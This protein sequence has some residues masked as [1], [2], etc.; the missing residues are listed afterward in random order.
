VQKALI[1]AASP[2]E[3]ALL[4]EKP[5]ERGVSLAAQSISAVGCCH[6]PQRI[7]CMLEANWGIPL[8]ELFVK[9]LNYADPQWDNPHS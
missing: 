6:H 4:V 2:L 8:P 7:I 1:K 5:M 3:A 9:T